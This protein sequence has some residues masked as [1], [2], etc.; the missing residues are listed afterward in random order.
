MDIFGVMTAII[1]ATISCFTILSQYLVRKKMVESLKMFYTQIAVDV[2]KLPGVTW[3]IVYGTHL[4]PRGLMDKAPDFGSW[5]CRFES[6][7][8]RFFS[9]KCLGHCNMPQ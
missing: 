7:H 9:E 3:L 8:G 1:F 2:E 5:D 4:R 6:C